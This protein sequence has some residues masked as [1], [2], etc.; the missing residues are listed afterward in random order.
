MVV[1]QRGGR[2]SRTSKKKKK[3]RNEAPSDDQATGC[4]ESMQESE[5]DEIHKANNTTKGSNLPSPM[6][7]YPR[8]SVGECKLLGVGEGR[9]SGV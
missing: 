5:S 1:K 2:R 7:P 4:G 6:I 8:V 3:R 9:A